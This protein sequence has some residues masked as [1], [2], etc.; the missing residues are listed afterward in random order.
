[1]CIIAYKPKN[2]KYERDVL[3][4]CYL[5]NNHGCGMSYIEN[6]EV[7][8]VKG[9]FKFEEFWELIRQVQENIESPIV[10]HFRVKSIGDIEEKNCHPFR[11]DA[12]HS[13]CHNGTIHAFA[14]T[15]SKLS[16]TV[17]FNHNILKP[18]FAEYPEFYKTKFGRFLIEETI[19]ERNKIVI[20]DADGSCTIFNESAGEWTPEGI[21]YSNKSY[22][23]PPI[24]KKKEKSIGNYFPSFGRNSFGRRNR[25]AKKEKPKSY[26]SSKDFINVEA[27]LLFLQDQ[28][29]TPKDINELNH[30]YAKQWCRRC[31]LKDLVSKG[32]VNAA[33]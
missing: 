17:L 19:K 28:K 11:I 12:K 16:D 1:M 18:M 14:A 15:N 8:I 7:K 31:R 30:F 3:E 26:H 6:G 24:P 32:I 2:Q 9:M 25:K 13:V 5:A 10:S 4:R 23:P 27:Q 21:W 33:Y 22:L 29:L 20:L